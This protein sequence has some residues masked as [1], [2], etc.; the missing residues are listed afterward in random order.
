MQEAPRHAAAAKVLLPRATS[1][2]ESTD[3]MAIHEG[4]FQYVGIIIQVR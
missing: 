3:C 1:Y 4:S 2:R